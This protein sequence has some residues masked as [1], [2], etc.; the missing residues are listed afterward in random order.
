L[1]K[2][3]T[4]AKDCRTQRNHPAL[5]LT[6]G[7]TNAEE[8]EKVSSNLTCWNILPRLLD[9]NDAGAA[10]GSGTDTSTSIIEWY[11]LTK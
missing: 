10:A 8:P 3:L 1:Q 2:T 7:E 9:R 11:S 5:L 4:L 6:N